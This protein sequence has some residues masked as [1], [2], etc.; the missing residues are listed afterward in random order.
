[1][2]KYF[3]SSVEIIFFFIKKPMPNNPIKCKHELKTWP[4][5]V[6]NDE[7][8]EITDKKKKPIIPWYPILNFNKDLL[9]IF[10]N[11]YTYPIVESVKKIIK[12]KNIICSDINY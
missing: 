2:K 7:I 3:I 10:E 6:I 12:N 9:N 8:I 11:I 4:W 1:M 5:L